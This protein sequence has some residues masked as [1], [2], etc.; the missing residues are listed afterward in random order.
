MGVVPCWGSGPCAQLANTEGGAQNVLIVGSGE[1]GHI[2]KTASAA[3]LAAGTAESEP[4]RIFAAERHPETLARHCVL[5]ATALDRSVGLRERTELFLEVYGNAFLSPKGLEYV[6][7]KA[8]QAARVLSGKTVEGDELLS[9]AV[10]WSLLKHKELDEVLDVL[11]QWRAGQ[12]LDMDKYWD[13]RLRRYYGSRYDYRKNAADWDYHMKLKPLAADVVGTR[14]FIKWRLHGIAFEFRDTSYT[15]PN[16]TMGTWVEGRRKGSSVMARGYWSDIVN[17]PYVTF[18]LSADNVKLFKVRNKEHVH[19]ACDVTEYNVSQL[20]H[21]L[22]TGEHI[23]PRVVQSGMGSFGDDAPSEDDL[24]AVNLSPS[25]QSSNPGLRLTLLLGEASKVC[26]RSRYHGLFDAVFVSALAASQASTWMNKIVRCPMEGEGEARPVVVVE[27]AM[28]AL[29]FK[30]EHKTEYVR[31]VYEAAREAGWKVQGEAPVEGQAQPRLQFVCTGEGVDIP[32]MEVPAGVAQS[33]AA[34][35]GE[36]EAPSDGELAL[37]TSSASSDTI[38]TGTQS[39]AGEL[40]QIKA[41]TGTEVTIV[42]RNP[43]RITRRPRELLVKVRLP[44]LS[45]AAGVD[46]DIDGEAKTVRVDHMGANLHATATLP[47]VVDSEA[48]K[49][50]FDSDTSLLV[51]TLPVIAPKEEDKNALQHLESEEGEEAASGNDS[52]KVEEPAFIKAQ[53][54]RGMTIPSKLGANIMF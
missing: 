6:K 53:Q 8:A 38:G 34:A 3:R 41:V 19:T 33:Q 37:T 22:H 47:F 12:V 30:P 52:N 20:L 11:L 4:V 9:E 17:S 16:I 15:V 5:L 36:R 27:T 42:Q 50:T 13:T 25:A 26:D 35:T 49:A 45:S 1:F 21:A 24:N 2:L 18:G 40:D 7:D 28:Y 31:R 29:D 43:D 14:E 44:G 51:L 39:A 54:V 46:I 10:D 23:R 32:E 48:G